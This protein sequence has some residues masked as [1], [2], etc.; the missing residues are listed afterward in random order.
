M[1]REDIKLLLFSTSTI[2]FHFPEKYLSKIMLILSPGLCQNT[3]VFSSNLSHPS[4]PMAFFCL[5]LAIPWSYNIGFNPSTQRHYRRLIYYLYIHSYMFRLYDHYQPE[6]K[7]TALGLLNWQRIRY[8][9]RSHIT[10]IVYIMLHIVDKRLLWATFSLR[11]VPSVYRY[12]R[13][14]ACQC[15]WGCSLRGDSPSWLSAT[16]SVWFS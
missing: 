1:T 6:S 15:S 8:F 7:I 4:K 5:Y 9:I 13:R 16:I 10:V 2:C 3:T 12:R 14:R 11:C